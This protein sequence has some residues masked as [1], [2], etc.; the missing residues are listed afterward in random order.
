MILYKYVSLDAAKAIISNSSLGFSSIKSLNDPFEGSYFGF[1]ETPNIPFELSVGA[2]RNKL[3]ANYAL[4]SLTRQPHNALM[5]AHYGA[6]HSGVVIGIDV[7]KAGFTDLETN[8]IPVQYGEVIYT[9]TKPHNM[10]ELLS[11]SELMAVGKGA[12]FESS[13]YNLL[14][15]AFLYKSLEW[16][17]EEE[18][19][20][21][22]DISST[23][24]RSKTRYGGFENS[25]GTWNKIPLNQRALYCL[26]V[27]RNSV[28]SVHIGEKSKLSSDILENW[29]LQGLKVYQC[30]AD[31]RSW[32]IISSCKK[33]GQQSI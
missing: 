8:V 9:S 30:H 16:A 1:R 3:E 24:Y 6:S 27:P 20:V 5:W 19:R 32:D 29:E 22:K 33:S 23:P 12:K 2:V 28:V 4:L 31:L 7:E 17:Y 11:S 26:D 14:K 21:V 18:V 10:F 25:S 13:T 15:R